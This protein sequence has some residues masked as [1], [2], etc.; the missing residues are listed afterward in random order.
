MDFF[1]T[2]VLVVAKVFS[3]GV[4]LVQLNIVKDSQGVCSSLGKVILSL[5]I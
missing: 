4:Y 2:K 1:L 5:G 3:F